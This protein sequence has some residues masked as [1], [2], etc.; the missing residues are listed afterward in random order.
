MAVDS[1]PAA[2]ETAG[3]C[4]RTKQRASQIGQLPW[5]KVEARTRKDE[6]KTCALYSHSNSTVVRLS[7]RMRWSSLRA[8]TQR[9]AQQANQQEAEEVEH[10]AGCAASTPLFQIELLSQIVGTLS[11]ST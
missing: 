10:C 1:S 4:Q 6:S 7:D 8:T 11:T 9:D 5:E 3:V 2:K